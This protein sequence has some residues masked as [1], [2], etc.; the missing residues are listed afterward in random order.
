[1]LAILV[2]SIVVVGYSQL[3]MQAVPSAVQPAAEQAIQGQE[4]GRRSVRLFSDPR[5]SH[6]AFEVENG[7]VYLGPVSRGQTILFFDGRRVFR[8]ANRKG[9]I[10]FTVSGNRIYAGPNTTGPIAYTVRNGR[11]F[12]GT[13]RGPIVYNIR[14]DRLFRG[15]NAT[16]RIVFEGNSRLSGSIQFL[17]PILA[18]RRF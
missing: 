6:L 2:L 17:L 14:G 5:K 15:P 1:M 9:E 11:V 3:P 4:V 12:E 16:G 13:E 18:D 8:G 10:L 7:R